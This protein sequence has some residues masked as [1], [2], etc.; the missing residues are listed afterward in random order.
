MQER[1]KSTIEDL[2]AR[3]VQ[4]PGQ[5]DQY[6]QP[7][8]P[9]K[10]ADHVQ[11]NLAQP[12]A[13]PSQAAPDQAIEAKEPYQA[14]PN[15]A[16][17]AKE[18]VQHWVLHPVPVSSQLLEYIPGRDS[19]ISAPDLAAGLDAFDACSGEHVLWATA[20]PHAAFK[21]VRP[22]VLR[23]TDCLPSIH[24]LLGD[25][26]MLGTLFWAFSVCCNGVHIMCKSS[27]QLL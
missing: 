2:S 3:F 13:Q 19:L 20:L 22:F 25:L 12:Q 1:A 6:H 26:L 11:P 5:H 8:N 9:A 17:H 14:A 4:P 24:V 16:Q 7:P 10:P 27:R 23:C 15:Q 21:F 18:Q